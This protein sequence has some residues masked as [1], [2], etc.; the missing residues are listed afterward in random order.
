MSSLVVQLRGAARRRRARALSLL[1][2]GT[3]VVVTAACADP[4][5]HLE[6][7]IESNVSLEFDDTR[8]IRYTSLAIQLEYSK[9]L[10]HT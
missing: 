3:L 10:V 1:V 7:S 4:P 6:G 9:R 8:M 5:N 2:V